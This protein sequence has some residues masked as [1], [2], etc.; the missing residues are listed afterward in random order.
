MLSARSDMLSC[1][2]ATLSDSG[3][4]LR[5]SFLKQRLQTRKQHPPGIVS[6]G[7]IH[8]IIMMVLSSGNIIMHLTV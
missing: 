1:M 4:A 6:T 7:L 8:M 5:S 2:Q 3:K